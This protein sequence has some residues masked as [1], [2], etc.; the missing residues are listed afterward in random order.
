MIELAAALAHGPLERFP[1]T[2]DPEACT[3]CSYRNACRE[4]PLVRED[5][6]GR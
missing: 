1:A 3:Y 4:R 6:F 5:R 2:H